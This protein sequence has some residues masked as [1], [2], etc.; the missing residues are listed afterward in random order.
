M[1]G[2]AAS[3]A[4][5]PAPTP[6]GEPSAQP[7][8][9]RPTMTP[10]T[11]DPQTADALRETRTGHDAL[12]LRVRGLTDRMGAQEIE[13]QRVRRRDQDERNRAYQQMRRRRA[14]T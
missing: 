3:A 1:C 7:T 4:T 13:A 8:Q 11:A 2:R 14:I 10:P 6:K 12:I 9:A 5:H